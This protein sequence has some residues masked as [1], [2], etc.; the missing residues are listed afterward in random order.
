[1]W[2]AG[3]H[4]LYSVLS[5]LSHSLTVNA[6]TA[7]RYSTLLL[8]LKQPN[9]ISTSTAT[10]T[11]GRKMLGQNFVILLNLL[12]SFSFQIYI[13]LYEN[14]SLPELKCWHFYQPT[15]SNSRVRHSVTADTCTVFDTYFLTNLPFGQPVFLFGSPPSKDLLSIKTHRKLVKMSIL[16]KMSLPDQRDCCYVSMVF[17]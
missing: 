9:V 1:M 5:Q 8:R 3:L 17:Q 6:T 13:F 14:N 10:Y 16:C 12:S 2:F 4:C 11:L 7:T 15:F